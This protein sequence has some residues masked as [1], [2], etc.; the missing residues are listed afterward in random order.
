MEGVVKRWNFC[1]REGTDE[2]EGEGVEGGR[3]W[4]GRGKEK[5][6][7]PILKILR[8][9]VQICS[10]HLVRSRADSSYLP[11]VVFFNLQRR[12]V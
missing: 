7:A 3:N 6:M 10:V 12:K 9:E 1:R 5:A 4:R 11:Q 2:R 8:E